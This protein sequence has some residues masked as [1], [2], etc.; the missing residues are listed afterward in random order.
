MRGCA[1]TKDSGGVNF[2]G[3]A[4][5]GGIILVGET[6]VSVL[7]EAIVRSGSSGGGNPRRKDIE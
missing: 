1:G 2:G 4:K 6:L 5:L 7:P 3:N